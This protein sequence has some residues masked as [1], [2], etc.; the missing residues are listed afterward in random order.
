M[1]YLCNYLFIYLFILLKKQASIGLEY[2]KG[3]KLVTYYN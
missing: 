3:E 1:C 2:H